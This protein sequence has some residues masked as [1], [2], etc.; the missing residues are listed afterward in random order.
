MDLACVHVHEYRNAQKLESDAPAQSVLE[1]RSTWNHRNSDVMSHLV[2]ESQ[3]ILKHLVP[4]LVDLVGALAVKL[5]PRVYRTKLAVPHAQS[6]LIHPL[7]L[8]LVATL[9]HPPLLVCARI[10]LS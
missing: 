3:L 10:W 8:L 2:V 6:V 7:S 4:L 9:E 1:G 5:L